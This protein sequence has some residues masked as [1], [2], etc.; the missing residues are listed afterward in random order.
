MQALTGPRSAES[1]ALPA[2]RAICGDATIGLWFRARDS[3]EGVVG[4]YKGVL[5]KMHHVEAHDFG[6]YFSG[7][8][9]SCHRQTMT[10][11]ARA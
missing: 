9:V 10:F 4:E 6:H 11:P 5:S 8:L 7:F 3:S 2:S 1:F